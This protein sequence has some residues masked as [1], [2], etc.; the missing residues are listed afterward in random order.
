M[1]EIIQTPVRTPRSRILVLVAVVLSIL[2]L[3]V[4]YG[5]GLIGLP[6]LILSKYQN[7]NCDFCSHAG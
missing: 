4:V 3:F 1:S 2:F 7:R 6:V 5:A